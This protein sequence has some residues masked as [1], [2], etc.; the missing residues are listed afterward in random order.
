MLVSSDYFAFKLFL[1]GNKYGI[2][3]AKIPYLL[4]HL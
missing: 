2:N 1:A 4:H 3:K